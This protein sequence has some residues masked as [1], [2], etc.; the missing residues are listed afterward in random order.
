[1]SSVLNVS[2]DSSK[3]QEF[4]IKDIVMF[5]NSEEQ[6]WFERIHV[7]KFLGLEDI[8]TSL[9][10][11]EK[12]EMLSRQ[13]LIPSGRTMSGW[14]GPKDQQ[15]KTGKFLSVFGVMY[16]IVNSKK[17][18]GKVLKK[19]ILK[20]IVP[21]GFDT[22][23]EEIQEK[24]R[25]AIE[26]KD[27]AIA[28]LNDDLKNGENEKVSLQ[29]EIGAKDQ[30]IAALQRRYVGYLSDE[31]KNNGISII[32]KNNDAVEYPYI[33]ANSMVIEGRRSGC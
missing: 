29:G 26:E 27:A 18:K 25:Q 8:R 17:D 4:S 33:Y 30:Q 5:V 11:L 10:G 3:P 6:N 14:S 23:F 24:H 15:N 22:R 12:C 7:G 1:M 9:N 13:E 16:I 2:N 20:D 32:A 19:H 28:L 21:R 31:D